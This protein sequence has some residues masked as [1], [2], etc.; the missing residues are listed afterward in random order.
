MRTCVILVTIYPF[1]FPWSLLTEALLQAGVAPSPSLGLQFH[2]RSGSVPLSFPHPVLPKL[3]QGESSGSCV[4]RPT[5]TRR[6][7]CLSQM[8][9]ARRRG[10]SCLSLSSLTGWRI[11]ARGVYLWKKQTYV[12]APSAVESKFCPGVLASQTIRLESSKILCVSKGA[13]FI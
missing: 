7:G 11:H 10:F 12:P 8:W 6:A 2:P 9:R 4:L 5:P 3:F 1:F 13:D